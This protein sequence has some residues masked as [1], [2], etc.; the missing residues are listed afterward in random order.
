MLISVSIVGDPRL[1]VVPK[2]VNFSVTPAPSQSFLPQPSLP[3]PEVE[4]AYAKSPRVD[5]KPKPV[6]G[7]TGLKLSPHGSCPY[8]AL[9]HPCSAP[10][11]GTPTDDVN[12]K[13][14]N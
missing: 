6:S 1:E 14:V 13:P 4:A 5:V 7:T 9:P 3:Q 12:D 2:P 10:D 11:I 8:S